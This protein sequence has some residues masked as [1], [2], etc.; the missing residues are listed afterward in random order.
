MG[1]ALALTNVVFYIVQAVSCTIVVKDIKICQGSVS[2]QTGKEIIEY[3]FSLSIW[4][5]ATLLVV[6]LDTT[7][8]G[9]YDF[10]S[11]ANYA[12]AAS[13]ITFILGIQNALFT[14]LIPAAA[15][16]EAREN[17]RELGI[18]L[19]TTTRYSMYLLL[20][21]GLPLVI[22]AKDILNFW[23]GPNYATTTA[24]LLQILIIANIVRLSALPYAMLLIGTGQQRLVVISP[25]IEGFSNLL[26]SIIGAALIGA[27]G[28]A[29]GTLIG[30]IIGIG[31]NLFYNMPRTTRIGIERTAYVQKGILTPLLCSIPL[32]IISLVAFLYRSFPSIYL[33]G[34]TICAFLVTIALVWQWGLEQKERLIF[35]SKKGFII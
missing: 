5:F 16:L 19:I 13:L 4:T 21:S 15:V 30:S 26:A 29:I 2:K 22:F 6:G 25:L 24:V 20:F 23:V 12:I 34:L 3:C 32:I 10:A 35:F 9:I 18:L 33:V 1:V 17:A 8:V 7:I 11:V 28:V 27:K 31:L 14:V